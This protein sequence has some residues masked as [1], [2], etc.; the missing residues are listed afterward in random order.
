MEILDATVSD[1]VEIIELQKRAYLSEAAI[2]DDYTI[3][4]LTQTIEE[5]VPDFRRKTILKVVDR[6]KIIGSV[7]GCMEDG[8]CLIGRLMVHPD[9]RRRGIGARL[10][11]AVE[12]RFR[13]ARS[14]E[15]FTGELSQDNIRLY[16]RLGYAI[17]RRES[18]AGSG[19]SLVIMRKVRACQAYHSD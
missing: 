11:G 3:P 7:N 8:A 14:W 13:A 9:F 4:P 18:L 16:E 12:E 15:L 17:A 10:M 2:Y 1:A 5:L 19:F 6:G